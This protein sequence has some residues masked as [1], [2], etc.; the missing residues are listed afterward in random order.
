MVTEELETEKRALVCIGACLEKK[1]RN[2]LIMEVS[3]FSSFTDFFVIC[4]GTSSRHVQAIA[5]FIQETM[6]KEGILPLGVEGE[7]VGTWI[8]L[9]YDDVV[10]H[11]FYEPV[12]E[13]YDIERLWPE[14]PRSAVED[15]A[16]A[17]AT[18]SLRA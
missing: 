9:D 5:A 2:V 7:A 8:L 14:A 3:E 6:K 17:P 16:P 18:L 10:V 12:R 4:S 1:A 13:F 11:V 15:D